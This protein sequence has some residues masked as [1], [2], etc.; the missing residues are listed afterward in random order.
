[1]KGPEVGGFLELCQ[2]SKRE[3]E[4]LFIAHR[5]CMKAIAE[6]PARS[7]TPEIRDIQGFEPKLAGIAAT[8][9]ITETVKDRPWSFK[10]IGIDNLVCIQKHIDVTY[11]TA[12]ASQLKVDSPEGMVD[13]ALT[14]SGPHQSELTELRDASLFIVRADGSDLRVFDPKQSIEPDGTRTFSYRVGWGPP[15]V[16]VL[17]VKD[18]YILRN[19][20][21]RVYGARAKGA[22]MIPCV[23]IEGK[24]Y[25]DME[26][27][28]PPAF[29]GESLVMSP[30]PPLLSDFF[31]GAAY[32]ARVLSRGKVIL[33]HPE[34]FDYPIEESKEFLASL[35]GQMTPATTLVQGQ[36]DFEPVTVQR[37]NWSEYV[38]GEKMILQAKRI[39]LR[40]R[41]EYQNRRVNFTFD[42]SDPIIVQTL[43]DTDYG[44]PDGHSYTEAE[45][46][47]SI[48]VRSLKIKKVA[49]RVNEYSLY[50][51]YKIAVHFYLT[52]V[53]KTGKFNQYGEP[54]Y[55]FKTDVKF[56]V[57][58]PK[59]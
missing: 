21:H 56:T 50:D 16:Q 8:D 23:L 33:L 40:V 46:E 14:G 43:T 1:M 52:R 49:E 53:S 9:R 35:P 38:V 7:L 57:I 47:S 10:L 58:P 26:N 27:Y 20:Y 17:H 25:A 31:G 2:I 54:R 37:E 13:F 24:T 12:A 36:V 11:A 59:N 41:R 48:T 22:S 28:G 5:S 18:R 34:E 45:L 44:P 19:G 30:K 6:L 3:R 29:F 15:F 55:L 4:D 32:D 42:V 39:L 51:G